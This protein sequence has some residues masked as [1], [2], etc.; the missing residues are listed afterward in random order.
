M[1]NTLGLSV[2][3]GAALGKKYFSTFDNAQQRATKLGAAFAETDKKLKA[4]NGV[5]KYRNQLS[6]LK[7]KQVGAFGSSKQLSE[8]IREVESK[9]WAANR[10]A[11]SYGVS[12]G[13]VER[14]QKSLAR[15][16]AVLERKLL[17]VNKA[18]AAKDRLTGMKSRA[19]GALG[20]A[21]GASRIVG[22]AM[23][24][25]RQEIRLQTVITPDDGDAKAAVMRARRHT[26]QFAKTSLA[27]QS[28]ILDIKYQLSS[29]GFS[30]DASKFGSE[31]VAKVA[32]VTDGSYGQVASIIGTTS[33]NMGADIAGSGVEDKLTRIGDV[34]TQTQLRY[35][36]DNFG[37]LGES[38]KM[39]AAQ[40]SLSRVPL[41]DTAVALG[42]LNSAGLRGSQ[43]GTA[44]S[45]TMR[46][47][48]KASEELGFSIVRNADGQMNL[49]STLRGVDEAL[50]VYDDIDEKGQVIQ[51][52]FGDEGKRGLAALLAG[53]DD[54]DEGLLAINK[55][56][57]VVAKLNELF[58]EGADG[59]WIMFKQNASLVGNVLANTVLPA[60]NFVLKPL[61]VF[62][63]LIGT[64]VEELP[65]I[66]WV[67]GGVTAGFLLSATAL[68]VITA[69]QWLW[70]TAMLAN[71]IGLVVA[72]VAILAGGALALYENWGSVMSW[73]SNTLDAI[74]DKF[75][76][77]SDLWTSVF[78]DGDKSVSVNTEQNRTEVLKKLE[79]PAARGASN[80]KTVNAPI[81]INAVPGMDAEEVARQVRAQ[82]DERDRDIKADQRNAMYS[83]E[84]FATP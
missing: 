27:S 9:F 67:L 48:Y 46:Q 78:G 80:T 11:K 71:P 45:A 41:E 62:F 40:A 6:K 14:D 76:W 4:A 79:A 77:I 36:I 10:A 3:I 19:V 83:N 5:I 2:V 74:A 60:I 35:Q 28:D 66:G 18:Q 52:L 75:T 30:E 58:E 51:D 20:A 70:N 13:D 17:R 42:L 49:I 81:T 34:L 84:E 61:G 16:S 47:M 33:N 55:S 12:L 7:A 69:A 82:L 39:A 8:E 26:L 59:P 63:G 25:A 37:Q 31:I 21:Y 43:A 32:T 56:T 72:G 38:M 24:T 44:F 68:G 50:S 73:W 22:G 15:Q 23:S 65:V 57:N 64:L 54:F 1:E 53:L 29:A